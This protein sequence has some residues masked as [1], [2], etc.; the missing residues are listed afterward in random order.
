MELAT[1]M[2]L[3]TVTVAAGFSLYLYFMKSI[4][5][6]SEEDKKVKNLQ[7]CFFAMQYDLNNS[8]KIIQTES[9]FSMYM[10]S[11]E[12]IN[13]KLEDTLLIRISKNEISDTFNLHTAD[14]LFN[15]ENQDQNTVHDFSYTTS[16]SKKEMIWKWRKEY[17]PVES[18]NQYIEEV[19]GN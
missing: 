12:I 8:E 16:F 9:G 15:S 4:L 6:H 13:Y 17:S 5:K 2:L 14:L 7:S 3:T 1:G 18:I 11:G 19:N 10:R